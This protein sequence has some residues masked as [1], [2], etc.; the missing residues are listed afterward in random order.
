MKKA[1]SLLAL[2]CLFSFAVSAQDQVPDFSGE[3]SLDKT[4]STLAGQLKLVESIKM[5]VTQNSKELKTETSTKIPNRPSS[6]G[7]EQLAYK[8]NGKETVAEVNAG[9]LTGTNTTGAKFEA[10]KLN[11]TL[12]RAGN[13]PMGE[14]TITIRE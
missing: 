12:V 4:K 9:N 8:L 10:G 3:W 6:A 1:V 11:L 13:T 2:I 5:K 7:G 14:F